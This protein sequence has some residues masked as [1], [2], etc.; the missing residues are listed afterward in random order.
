[1]YRENSL[2]KLFAKLCILFDIFLHYNISIHPTKSYLKHLNIALL[3][4]QV[5]SLGFPTSGEKLKTVRLLRYLETLGTL[6]YYLGL[7]EYLR[8]YIQY[9]AQLASL[10]QALKTNLLK[11]T[12]ESG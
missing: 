7:I 8:S 3:G 11:R 5:N 4:Q 10:L 12:P 6:E 2:A 1:M 9:Y